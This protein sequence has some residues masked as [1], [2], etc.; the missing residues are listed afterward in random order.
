MMYPGWWMMDGATYTLNVW[1]W[2]TVDA[3]LSFLRYNDVYLS[4]S[5]Q[6]YIGLQKGST[7]QFCLVGGFNHIEKY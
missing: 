7:F 6:I 1:S 5:Y 4:L 2:M 3:H